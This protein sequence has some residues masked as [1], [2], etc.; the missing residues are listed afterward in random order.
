MRASEIEP[1][2]IE[3]LLFPYLPKGKIAAIAGQMGQGKS[4][5]TIWLAKYVTSLGGSVV[6]L[7][8][9]DDPADTIR[10]RLEAALRRAEYLAAR[11][12][13]ADLI[14]KDEGG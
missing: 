3:F 13:F 8:A 6:M 7:S 5:V 11:H 12:D 9:E 10:P 1:Q 14:G 4:L 2:A